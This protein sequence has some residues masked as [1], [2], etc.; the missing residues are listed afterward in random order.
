MCVAFFPVLLSRTHFCCRQAFA[1]A[2]GEAFP[3]QSLFPL[4]LLL[5]R[6][7][8]QLFFFAGFGDLALVN[9]IIFLPRTPM[10]LQ[11]A[12]EFAIEKFNSRQLGGALKRVLSRYLLSPVVRESWMIEANIWFEGKFTRRFVIIH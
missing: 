6:T 2:C 10:L 5:G 11:D 9:L 3:F 8:K 4:L 1:K 12:L 7:G